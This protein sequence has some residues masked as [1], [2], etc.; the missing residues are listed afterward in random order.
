MAHPSGPTK[1][2]QNVNNT[3]FD[4]IEG[5]PRLKLCPNSIL[6]FRYSFINHVFMYFS[7]MTRPKRCGGHWLGH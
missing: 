2:I 4:R 7:T 5:F 1:I 6:K 3:T